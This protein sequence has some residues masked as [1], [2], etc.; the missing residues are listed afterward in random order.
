[1][2]TEMSA[3]KIW[4]EKVPKE[5]QKKI[6]ENVF[7]GNCSQKTGNCVT[8]IVDYEIQNSKLGDIVLKGKCKR[9]GQE[10][11]RVVETGD[12]VSHLS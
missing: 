12:T 9:C 7:C 6:V 4:N 10:V 3:F 8:T 11:A 2:T 1:M 5:F